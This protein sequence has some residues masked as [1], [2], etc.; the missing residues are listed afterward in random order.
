MANAVVGTRVGRRID[1]WATRKLAPL[2]TSMARKPGSAQLA[3][4]ISNLGG[5]AA[6]GIGYRSWN[7][8]TSLELAAQTES[9]DTYDELVAAYKPDLTSST[10]MDSL[11]KGG[12]LAALTTGHVIAFHCLVST[13]VAFMSSPLNAPEDISGRFGV[14]EFLYGS[15]HSIVDL[16]M[17][18]AC[19]HTAV[20]VH[21]MAHFLKAVEQNAL[22]KEAREETAR[23]KAQG[24]FRQ[25]LWYGEMFVKI[26]WG[27]F[28]GVRRNGLDYEITSDGY[29]MAVS[30]AGPSVMGKLAKLALPVGIAAGIAAEVSGLFGFHYLA[31]PLVGLAF[32]GLGDRFLAD[33]G[34][35][36]KYR[37]WVKATEKGASEVA[38][39]SAEEIKDLLGKIKG[40]LVDTSKRMKRITLADGRVL[41]LPWQFRNCGQGGR[42]TE[43]EFPDS[44]ISMQESMFVPLRAKSYEE[45]QEMT[46]TL[47]RQLNTR[48]ANDE[49]GC[50]VMGKGTEGGLAAYIE[51]EEGDKV[52]EQRLWRI[53]TQVIRDC[54]WVPGEDVAIALDPAASELENM[55]RQIHDKPNSIGQYCFW[56]HPAKPVLSRD[57]VVDLYL[58]AVERD[59]VPI[60]S[61]EDG[62]GERDIKGWKLIMEKLNHIC[63]VV[64]DDIATTND[65]IV[66]MYARQG[67]FDTLLVKLNQI[68]T[69][70]EAV[71]AMLTAMAY[72][73]ELIISHRSQSTFDPFEGDIAVAMDAL[74][75][76]AG[77]GS[78]SERQAKYERIIEI[79][80]LAVREAR[81]LT[82]LEREQVEVGL[83]SL[84][85]SLTGTPADEVELVDGA[86]D[87]DVLRLVMGMLHLEGIYGKETATNSG[88]P[89]TAVTAILG[90][91]NVLRFTSGTPVGASAGVTE[92]TH[93]VDS[94]I[95]PCAATETHADLFNQQMVMTETGE[96]VWTGVYNFRKGLSRSDIE[97]KQDASLLPLWDR[98]Q[99]YK[100]KGTLTAA[101]HVD[102]ILAA[103][104]VGKKVA[105]LGGVVGIDRTLLSIE[106]YHAV[107]AGKIDENSSW[108]DQVAAM[109]RKGIIGM[110]PILAL[111]LSLG[112]AAAAVEGKELWEPIREMAAET[113]A[114]FVAAHGEHDVAV[115]WRQI[116]ENNGF[117]ELKVLYQAAAQNLIDA[118]DLIH[119]RLRE[120]LPVYDVPEVV[121]ARRIFTDPEILA[122]LDKGHQKKME[123]L[124][125]V[126]V[127][128]G[129]YAYEA[130]VEAGPKGAGQLTPPMVHKVRI[131]EGS[132]TGLGER[133]VSNAEGRWVVGDD[134]KGQ[135]LGTR[136]IFVDAIGTDK[137]LDDEE[138]LV[139]VA[140]PIMRGAERGR[141]KMVLGRFSDDMDV[142]QKKV[143]FAEQ[144][145]AIRATV[146]DR[147][148]DPAQTG[149]EE[150]FDQAFSKIPMLEF[151]RRSAFGLYEGYIRPEFEG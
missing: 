4:G 122:Q 22:S 139:S 63:R 112:R 115:D 42:H 51:A 17:A 91:S 23:I 130:T 128:H 44:N 8:G 43:G 20:S 10:F 6:L 150:R 71:L 9:L 19:F 74:G 90:K 119:P 120:F 81:P 107:A 98:A 69:V 88:T 108:E 129:T 125:E 29:N 45:A 92:A 124:S 133:Y 2:A 85:A 127:P 59:G 58:T 145:N 56:R 14:L 80:E 141:I 25:A 100:G 75:I 101:E 111:S 137:G 3:R 149:F 78:N 72:K 24:K 109:Q 93:Y 148:T 31:R 32:I 102:K 73:I 117:Q 116:R 87:I 134:S 41:M 47:Q 28:Y 26:P 94:M 12:A 99:R 54:G 1:L 34:E 76:K 135:R 48:L 132:R 39:Q 21:E 15:N 83:K 35:L 123:I 105:D 16:L 65:R 114:K 79:F 113:M 103:T 89:T 131:A 143:I 126:F 18:Y 82:G 68:G 67:L 11:A 36:G 61:I 64:G 60:C 50:K 104:F 33:R 84:V 37:A 13:H 97:A 106:R 55:Y 142:A 66:E 140:I 95:R 144:Y 118:D 49:A 96:E 70:S 57:E 138:D 146:R 27:K 53:M 151:F 136:R 46:V 121:R 30:A 147:G 40:M 110:N 62:A 52:P 86:A 38:D 77:G 5:W 7:V